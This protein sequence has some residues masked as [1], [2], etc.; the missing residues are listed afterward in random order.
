MFQV[1]VLSLTPHQLQSLVDAQG[2]ASP[3][4]SLQTLI[5]GGSKTPSALLSLARSRICNNLMIGYG[6][7]EAGSIS[8][9][10]AAAVEGME[11]AAGRVLPWAELQAVDE[12]GAPV[13]PG[14]QGLLRV[15]S[16][17][18]AAG[19]VTETVSNLEPL[20]K[21]WF[22][23]GDLGAIGEDGMVIV[24]GR[25]TELINRGGSIIA[26]DLVE[27]VLSA[28]PM[29]ADCAAFGAMTGSGFEEIWAAIVPGDGYDP[30][31]L[32]HFCRERLADKTPDKLLTVT[33]IPRNDMGKVMRRSV[34]DAVLSG[35]LHLPSSR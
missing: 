23:P 11:N 32:L 16:N 14:Q 25:S 35:A 8:H 18:M 19:Y 7:T 1:N 9:V 20:G 4:P 2:A 3:P 26:P 33:E 15:R 28:S 30:Q 12:A 24:S 22:Y 34:R 6:T 31:K 27:Q 10:H 5:V 17:E 21:D 29:V 13:P